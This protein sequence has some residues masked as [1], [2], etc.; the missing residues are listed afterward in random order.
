[1]ANKLWFRPKKPG[2]KRILIHAINHVGLGHINRSIAVA[3]WLQAGVP[4]LDILFLIEGGEDFIEPSG[5]PWIL[6]PGQPTE[7]EHCEQIV[8]SVLDVFRPDLMLYETLIR[9]Q[10]HRPVQELG[11][12]KAVMG[13]VG[14]ALRDQF[15]KFLP[16]T[17][18]VDLVIILSQKP[19]VTPADQDLIARY[20]GR[21]I[22]AGPLVRQK[23]KFDGSALRAKLG[24]N[25]S[26]KIV[27]ITFGGGGWD[28]AREV[29]ANLL[30][31]RTHILARYPQTK[32]VVITGPHFSS[33]LPPVDDF[34]VHSS[35]FEP[36]LTDYINISSVVVSMAGYST[37]NEVAGSGI[38]AIVIPASEAEDQVGPGS[39][40]EYAR[41]F[42]N[43]VVSSEIQ[44]EV[45]QHLLTALNRERDLSA[46]ADFWQRAEVA[47]QTIVGAIKMLLND[48]V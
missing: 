41:G 4:N 20:Q 15:T 36:F 45:V 34:V 23:Y 26:D 6:V 19:E 17:R 33:D 5:Y 37:V 10:I 29:L 8:R 48:T 1:M 2:E 14:D 42:S 7:S 28:V 32:F 12:K 9:E 24:V 43:I 16:L 46:I 30:S 44:Q 21:T 38:P 35:R 25:D 18:E 31:A 39:M 13:N 11:I 27:L 47:S 3:Q 22:Y 40:S